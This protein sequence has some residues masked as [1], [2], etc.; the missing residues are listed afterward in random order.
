MTEG[1]EFTQVGYISI[2]QKGEWKVDY[3]SYATKEPTLQIAIGTLLGPLVSGLERN[4]D[5]YIEVNDAK[6]KES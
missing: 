2:N 5:K 6:D 3:V 4:K 1:S